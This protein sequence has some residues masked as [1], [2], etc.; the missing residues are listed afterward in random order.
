M[1]YVPLKSESLAR[2]LV[3]LDACGNISVTGSVR[4]MQTIYNWP[5][6]GQ[7]RMG[8]WIYNIGPDAVDK[9]RAARILNGD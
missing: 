3:N 5:K 1:R 2:R 6:N 4:G 8:A 9:L 7:V